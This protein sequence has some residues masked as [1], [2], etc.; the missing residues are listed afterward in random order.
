MGNTNEPRLRG[1]NLGG[2]EQKDAV[3]HATYAKNRN[4]DA[5]LH[6]DD[7]K[8]TLLDDGLDIE[9]DSDTR[10]GTRGNTNHG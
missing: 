7:E 4:P 8:D 1:S 10:A 6:L 3:D 9:D 5:E 2:A